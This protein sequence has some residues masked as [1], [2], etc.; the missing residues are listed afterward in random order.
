VD[1]ANGLHVRPVSVPFK[2]FV[3]SKDKLKLPIRYLLPW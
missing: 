3:V 2:E 1:G